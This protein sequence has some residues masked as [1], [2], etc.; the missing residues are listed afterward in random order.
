ML[1][2]SCQFAVAASQHQPD[3]PEGF[4]GWFAVNVCLGGCQ[5]TLGQRGT[6]N[7]RT[8]L[9]R[10]SNPISEELPSTISAD[11]NSDVSHAEVDLKNLPA[12]YE[13]TRNYVVQEKLG[14][15]GFGVVYKVIDTLGRRIAGVKII[16]PGRYSSVDKVKQEFKTLDKLPPHERVVRVIH[17]GF[18]RSDTPYIAFDFVDGLDVGDLI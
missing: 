5:S 7:L 3:L 2:Q 8:I 17:P 15:G 12:G 16:L 4:D 10:A 9:A 14:S 18:L 6:G 11:S 13:L 1:E